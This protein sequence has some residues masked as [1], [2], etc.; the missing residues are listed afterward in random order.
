LPRAA[1]RQPNNVVGGRRVRRAPKEST[2]AER[3][4]EWRAAKERDWS[5]RYVREVGRIAAK[6]IEPALG[7]RPLVETMRADWV[8]MV[9]AKRKRAPAMASA[10]YR[11]CSAFL[12]HAEASGWVGVSLL[13]RKGLAT[14]APTAAARK[15]VLSDDEL[16][17]VWRASATL[18][19]KPRA[20][21]RLLVLS[22]A[23]EMEV[24]DIASGEVDRDAARWTIPAE[25]A[26]N[27]RAI[28]LP[29]GPAALTELAAVWPNE[30]V[31]A[32]RKLLPVRGFSKLK[33]KIDKLSGVE[34]WRW[35]DLRR[36][37]R[38]GM[39]RLGVPRDHAEAALNHVTG[40]TAL[41][42]TYD[43]HDYAIEIIAASEKWQGHVASLV[44]RPWKFGAKVAW[45]NSLLM[46]WAEG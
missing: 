13:P 24:A 29:L 6:D 20:F 25:R 31:P 35:H 39:P 26:K 10:L 28:T 7:K 17:A 44:A 37:A 15:R 3:L 11:V 43:R 12:N 36:T 38:I 34:D 33:A 40:R 2:V 41:E 42:R 45:P 4:T 19:P 46:H 5:E 21:V 22:A 23:R 8:V 1:I 32:Y 18:P 14:L 27:G 9:A 30:T 16:V